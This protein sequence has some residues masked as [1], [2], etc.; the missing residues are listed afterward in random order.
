MAQAIQLQFRRGCTAGCRACMLLKRILRRMLIASPSEPAR[1]V[2]ALCGLRAW[3]VVPLLLLSGSCVFELPELE[4]PGIGGASG[5]GA[6]AGASPFAGNAGGPGGSS[7]GGSAGSQNPACPPDQKL[8][9]DVC[10]PT[11]P[12]YG[13]ESTSCEPCGAAAHAIVACQEGQCAVTECEPGFADC[14]GDAINSVG[15]ISGNGCEYPL[16]VASPTVPILSVPF[17]HIQ[18]DG[19]RDDWNAL[20]SY[21]FEKFCANCKDEQ[22]KPVSAD[23]TIPP[24][25]DLD[26]RFR[27]AWDNDKFYVLVEAFDNQLF[28]SGVPGDGCQQTGASCEDSA[29]VFFLGKEDRTHG[30]FNDN[31]RVFLGLSGHVAAP[32][33][34]PPAA[35]DVEIKAVVQGNFCYRIEAQVDWAYITNTKSNPGSAPGHFPPAVNQS[36]GFDIA[37]NDWDAPISDSNGIQR[38]SQIF[39]SEPGPEFGAKT[40]GIGTMTLIGGVDAGL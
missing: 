25:T 33:Q 1:R 29:Q 13:C 35:G 31:Q 39:W 15:V 3:F 17:A 2:T 8:C 9:G 27:V 37:V 19:Q 12:A 26:A 7:A 28:A 24:R 23:G 30:Y 16:G 21:A 22:T 11:T 4:G 36:Y 38:Q 14:N 18:V 20:P 6:Q 10:R 32:G 34:G 40:E 5:L